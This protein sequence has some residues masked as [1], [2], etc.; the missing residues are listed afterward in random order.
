MTTGLDGWWLEFATPPGFWY[1]FAAASAPRD[2]RQ[3][4]TVGSSDVC[5]DHS[6]YDPTFGS[7]RSV[8]FECGGRGE[9]DPINVG[10]RRHFP[11]GMASD[12]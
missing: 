2:E 6:S 1:R 9:F 10:Y 8:L 4:T 3:P 5:V 12:A 11:A 7:N